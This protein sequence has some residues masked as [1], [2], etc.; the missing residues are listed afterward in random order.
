MVITL[1]TSGLGNQMFQY[2]AGRALAARLG[3]TLKLDISYYANNPHT[4]RY[5]D[6]ERYC[7]SSTIAKP[8]EVQ[9]LQRLARPRIAKLTQ[10]LRLLG[11]PLQST[12]LLDPVQGYQA[13]CESVKGH[14][15][16]SGMWQ[17]EKYFAAYAD[18]IRR[19]F[20]YRQEPDAANRAAI[21]EIH[22]TESVCLHVRRGDKVHIPEVGACDLSYYEKAIAVVMERV[23]HPHFFIFS[24]DA[25]WTREHVTT[26]AP[27]TYITH[28]T[29]RNDAEDMRLM[30]HCKH[31]VIANST[32]SWW[33]AWLATNP[34]KLV[35]SPSSYFADPNISM[36]DRIPE[37]WVQL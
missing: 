8:W 1:I 2:A 17:S 23:A 15:Y 7:L 18:V 20:A 10:P 11:L 37:A 35:I 26:P 29:G 28:N 12:V 33:G 21:E 30:S 3:T 36:L 22:A 32:F 13:E 9:L 34:S 16:L 25:A 19:D 4:R 27:S 5:Y 24:D 31:F 14:A 6:L